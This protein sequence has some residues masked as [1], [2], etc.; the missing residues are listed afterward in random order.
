MATRDEIIAIPDRYIAAVSAG[1][2]DTIMSLYNDNPRVEDPIGEPAHEGADA[3]R[4]FYTQLS[5]SGF[6]INLTRITPVCVAGGNE[7]AFAFRVDV[8]LGEMTMSM[9]THDTMV[10]DED[11]R[12]SQMRAYADSQAT[13]ES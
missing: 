3:V 12:I 1:D 13:P 8:D 7:A 11:G 9:V 10:F 4:A 5:Q 2:V 6:K